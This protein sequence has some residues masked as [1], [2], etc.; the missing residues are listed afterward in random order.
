MT[1]LRDWAPPGIGVLAA[2]S[3]LA[4]VPGGPAAPGSRSGHD[5]HGGLIGRGSFNVSPQAVAEL[6]GRD[7]NLGMM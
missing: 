7:Q 1:D 4:E 3:A 2:A 5:G 6:G